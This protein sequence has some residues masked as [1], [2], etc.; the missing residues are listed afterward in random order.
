MSPDR[1]FER[2]RALADSEFCGMTWEMRRSVSY[3]FYSKYIRSIDR[4]VDSYRGTNLIGLDS[5]WAQ[6]AATFLDWSKSDTV[7][8]GWIPKKTFNVVRLIFWQVSKERLWQWNWILG[9]TI[10]EFWPAWMGL[11]TLRWNRRKSMWAGNWSINMGIVLFEAITCCIYR[12]IWSSGQSR[13]SEFGNESNHDWECM[14]NSDRYQS[15]SKE[16]KQQRNIDEQEEIVKRNQVLATC[17]AIC[18]ASWR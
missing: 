3:V 8:E 16:E 10:V 1:S 13:Y 2:S 9:W 17:W 11:W 7:K 4:K 15:S 18:L 14:S 12:R 6:S 5:I